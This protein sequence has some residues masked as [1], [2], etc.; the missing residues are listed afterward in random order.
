MLDI[1]KDVRQWAK[2]C[3][4]CQKSK[5][6][7]RTITLLS[8]FV[9]P[10]VLFAHIRIDIVRLLPVFQGNTY[11]TSQSMVVLVRGIGMACNL[12]EV[13]GKW[14][15]SVSVCCSRAISL[16]STAEACAVCIVSTHDKV[17]AMRLS[18]PLTW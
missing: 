4:K 10:D 18:E 11:E 3:L 17:S 13:C 8:T 7:C 16:K 15:S 5:I 12:S 14:V 2:S 1:N 6:Q 9:T